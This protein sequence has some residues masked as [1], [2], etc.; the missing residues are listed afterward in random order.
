MIGKFFSAALRKAPREAEVFDQDVEASKRE[1]EAF[2][3]PAMT[4]L[5]P[6]VAQNDDPL[7]SLCSTVEEDLRAAGY[8]R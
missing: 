2:S 5:Q 1:A 7:N 8:L 4:P 6:P 3:F